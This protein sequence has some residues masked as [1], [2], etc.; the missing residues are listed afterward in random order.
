MYSQIPDFQIVLSWPNIVLSNH[1]SMESL[2]IHE[3]YISI[4]KN[5]P[6]DGMRFC[7]PG[8]QYYKKYKKCYYIIIN[9]IETKYCISLMNT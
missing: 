5:G 9:I 1:T 7:G 2:F 8:S 4:K 3:V 6:Y